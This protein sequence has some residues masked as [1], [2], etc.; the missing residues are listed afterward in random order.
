LNALHFSFAL[1]LIASSAVAAERGE[2]VTIAERYMFDSKVL[3]EKRSYVV[4][5]PWNYEL[6]NE[7]YPVLVFLDAESNIN[8]VAAVA[9]VLS[10]TARSM[11]M[12]VIGIENTDRQRDMTPPLLNENPTFVPA[13][14]IGGAPEFLS[15]IVDELLPH[16]DQTYRTR[17]TRILVGYSY[18]GLFTLYTLFNR[19]KA[20]TAYI[21]ASPGLWWDDESMA[22][23]AQT[24]LDTHKDVRVSL[25]MTMANEGGAMLSGAHRLM[26]VLATAPQVVSTSFQHWPHE[27]H[28]SI[29]MPTV[30]KGMEWLHETYYTHNPPQAYERYGLENIDKRFTA[31]SQYLGYKVKPPEAVFNE[32]GQYLMETKRW[33]EARIVLEKQMSM[34]P[35]DIFAMTQLANVCLQLN[36]RECAVARI[37]RSLELYPGNPDAPALATKAGIDLQR[38]RQSKEIP[39]AVRRKHVGRYESPEG[40]LSVTFDEGKLFVSVKNEK[41]ELIAMSDLKFYALGSDREY[42]FVRSAPG[43][44]TSVTV[45]LPEK[46]VDSPRIVN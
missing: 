18:S 31:L 20:F 3:D 30:Y 4:H 33:S 42:T 40:V 38:V 34:Y 23:Q 45:H 7:A 13:G 2:P 36:D 9:D 26:G 11:R 43:A 14:A 41:R 5:K 29:N 44:T 27:S 8:Q 12:L 24:F 15:F 46:D 10:N 17:P 25:Y 6:S 21:A 1:L 37:E 16:I 19:P 22:T 39:S 28:S 32:I 35:T